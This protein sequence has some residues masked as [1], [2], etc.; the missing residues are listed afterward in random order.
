MLSG[1]KRLM[2]GHE[3]RFE[4]FAHL[5]LSLPSLSVAIV[6]RAGGKAARLPTSCEVC[7]EM[8]SEYPFIAKH[9]ASGHREYHTVC[10]LRIGL[11]LHTRQ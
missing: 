9:N 8:I 5:G 1:P 7:P 4:R 10:A 6:K 11:I 3:T 2:E